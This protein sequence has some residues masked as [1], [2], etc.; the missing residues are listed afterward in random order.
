MLICIIKKEIKKLLKIDKENREIE[1]LKDVE[2]FKDD[3]R[4]CFAAT[5]IVSQKEENNDI[6]VEDLEGIIQNPTKKVEEITKYF[7]KYF[8]TR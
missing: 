7:K 6:V 2:K 3:S 4:A 1:K 5:R 8:Q